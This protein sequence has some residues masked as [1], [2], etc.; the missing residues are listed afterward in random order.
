MLRRCASTV[1]RLTHKVDRWRNGGMAL[2]WAAAS[3]LEAEKTMRK[4]GGCQQVWMLAAALER[5]NQ[6]ADRL[7]T[8][9]KAG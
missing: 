3:F 2:R 6:A 9:R 8:A 5:S 7:A 4:I 1:R